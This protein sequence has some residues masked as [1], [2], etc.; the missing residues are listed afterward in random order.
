MTKNRSCFTSWQ[1]SNSIIVTKGTQALSN[2]ELSLFEPDKCSHEEADRI[3]VHARYAAGQGSKSI[4]VKANDTD[5]LVIGMSV[6]PTLQ[7]MGLQQ[8]WLHLAKVRA[9]DGLAFTACATMLVKRR[10]KVCHSFIHLQV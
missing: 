5:V 8:L 4:M 9:F 7:D 1:T 6:F 2:H 3:F 10:Q